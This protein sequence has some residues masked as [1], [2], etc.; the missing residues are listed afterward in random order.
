MKE[1]KNNI[2]LDKVIGLIT[3][4]TILIFVGMIYI[5]FRP[6]K[7]SVETANETETTEAVNEATDAQ[8]GKSVTVCIDAG[9][10]GTDG[11]SG[12]S[13][14]EKTQTLAVALKVQ[15]YLE[16]SG[17]NVV[18]TR[19]T[20]V[21]VTDEQRVQTGNQAGAAAMVSIHRNYYEGPENVYGAEAW[22]HSSG[23]ADAKS[24]AAGILEKLHTAVDEDNRGV[25]LGSVDGSGDYYINTHSKCA[26][27]ILELG[28]MTSTADDALVTTDID[29]AS[30]AVADG[31]INYLKIMGYLNG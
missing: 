5:D 15:K 7:K 13:G 3:L 2:R 22:I 14:K 17:V 31:I 9:H 24:L 21:A 19:T 27:C 4:I 12:T 23:S 16:E 18:M 28:Y 25:K 10:G 11:G 30:K 20:D 6:S 1:Q 29:A 26:S 8:N